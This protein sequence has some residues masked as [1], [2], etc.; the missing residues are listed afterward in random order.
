MAFLNGIF[1]NKQGQQQPQQN[2]VQHPNQPQQQNPQGQ[3]QQPQGQQ[4]SSGAGG[5]A[6]S[7]QT[8]QNTNYQGAQNP[9][10]PL[11]P[12]M[13]L[14]TPSPD[15]L[16]AQ[17]AQAKPTGLFGDQFN[18]DNINKALTGQNFVGQ[19]DP[20][21]MQAALGGDANAM[22]EILNSVG[23]NAASMAIQASRGM[24]EHGVKT[25][26]EQFSGS[27]DSRFREYQMK[28]QTP[29]N[30]ALKHP[31]GQAF[32][33][34]ASK[35]IATANPRMPAHEITAQAEQM[36]EQLAQQINPA[37]ANSDQNSGKPAGTDWETM[38][39]NDGNQP[40]Q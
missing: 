32:L 34:M 10:N 23:S 1:G 31:L 21:K 4:N 26:T 38:F 29:K 17:Q 28:Q 9:A 37:K 7:Q 8:P 24:V 3:Q 25:G 5:P 2:Q 14:M 18:P 13:Q 40:T 16:A 35:Q 15:V 19:V 22:M 20:A 36:F 11:D 30:E 27:L 12:F 39:L 33:Q 6:G